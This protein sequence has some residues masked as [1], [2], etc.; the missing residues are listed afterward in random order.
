MSPL[1]HDPAPAPCLC[2][3]PCINFCTALRHSP[4]AL[5]RR[6]VII[7][8]D[9]GPCHLGHPDVRFTACI[10]HP[11]LSPHM[12]S[13]L[14]SI[15]NDSTFIFFLH[16]SS[17]V[18][19]LCVRCSGTD[20]PVCILEKWA[21]SSGPLTI[22]PYNIICKLSFF[23]CFRFKPTMSS[24]LGHLIECRLPRCL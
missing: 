4:S 11:T 23:V 18:I 21:N 9:N 20:L 8:G 17:T 19:T 13:H 5:R 2:P 1:S 16:R 15:S 7:A 24:W 12:S 3:C 10:D 6:L 14:E 22:F